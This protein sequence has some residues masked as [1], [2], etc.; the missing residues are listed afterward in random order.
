VRHVTAA[1]TEHLADARTR[2]HRREKR[3]VL[4]DPRFQTPSPIRP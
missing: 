2:A 1:Y 3:R 4:G